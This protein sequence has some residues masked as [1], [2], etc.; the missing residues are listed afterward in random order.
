MIRIV[1]TVIVL[2]P[3]IL[4]LSG[5]IITQAEKEA[6][7]AATS[8]IHKMGEIVKSREQAFLHAYEAAIVRQLETQREIQKQRWLAAKAEQKTKVWA[9]TEKKLNQTL[10]NAKTDLES[11]LT[12][13][14]E[15]LDL[16]LAETR[17]AG[18]SPETEASLALQLSATL[19]NA[20]KEYADIRDAATREMVRTRSEL[21]QV[22]EDAYAIPDFLTNGTNDVATA[23]ELLSTLSDDSEKFLES[24]EA[25]VTELKDYINRPS[26]LELF[27][28]GLLGDKLF[29]SIESRLKKTVDELSLKTGTEIDKAVSS[30]S[31]KSQIFLNNQK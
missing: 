28:Q 30:V 7:V 1:K 23:R 2:F 27:A 25:A 19:A 18:D 15:R 13:L 29:E 5:C 16:S 24:M 31:E 6:A 26:D 9:K 4:F 12:P 17:A 3:A 20:E 21:L 11:A 14:L 10:E 8:S 22:V